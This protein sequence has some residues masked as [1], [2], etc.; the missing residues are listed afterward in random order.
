MQTI[1]VYNENQVEEQREFQNL[2]SDDKIWLD[3]VDPTDNDL[4][5][6]VGY[7]HLDQSAVELVKNKSKKPQIRLLDDHTFT[8]LLD[9]KYKD[10]QTVVT[11]GL[12]LF[13]GKNWLITIHPTKMDL[14]KSTR[15]LLEHENKRLLKDSIDALFYSILSEVI[16][17]YE[18]VL[19]A[20]ELT[21][22]DLE[23]KALSDPKK[24]TINHLDRLSRQ[25]IVFRRHFWRVRDVVNFLKY[26]EK[27]TDEVKYIQMA[28]DNITQLLELVES[29]RDTI[30]SVRDLYIAN[31][32][33]QMND[34]MRTLTIFAAILL[35][36]TLVVGIYS[37]NGV[38]FITT[39]PSGFIILLTTL[40]II[41]GGLLYLFIKKNWIVLKGNKMLPKD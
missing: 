15:K 7:F 28:Y 29:Y 34:T 3:L 35:P 38:D 12:Y 24:E 23:E 36:L 5:S 37:M 31:I 20:V 6:F 2:K 16:D 40:I 1:I 4:E 25:L 13:C 11:E 18:Q 39:L 27:D 30:N 14:V 10:S 32:S 9:I 8:I 41:T 19:T 22:T 17:R 21:M 26:I 33:L